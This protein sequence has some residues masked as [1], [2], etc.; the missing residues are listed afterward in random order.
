MSAGPQKRG[1][2]KVRAHPPQ[3]RP[4]SSS[5]PWKGRKICHLSFLNPGVSS[6]LELWSLTN[7]ASG[8]SLGDCC[9]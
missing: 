2:D 3:S 4:R 6:S 5:V 8:A 7:W 9:C 1:D